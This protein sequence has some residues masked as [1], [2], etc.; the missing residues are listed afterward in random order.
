MPWIFDQTYI[1]LL[2]HGIIHLRVAVSNAQRMQLVSSQPRFLRA[3]KMTI[4]L[5]LFLRASTHSEVLSSERA[6][7]KPRLLLRLSGVLLLRYDKRQ[8]LAS[9]FQLPPRFT[10]LEPLSDC[11]LLFLFVGRLCEKPCFLHAARRTA[12]GGYAPERLT[13]SMSLR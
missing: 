13:P 6:R 10:R 9:L 5:Q 7:R 11:H 4:C 12:M 1:L 2:I 3:F 8:L